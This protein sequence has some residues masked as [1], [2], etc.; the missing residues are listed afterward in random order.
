MSWGFVL[1]TDTASFRHGFDTARSYLADRLN[2][3]EGCGR[4]LRHAPLATPSL[5]GGSTPVVTTVPG[6]YVAVTCS[7]IGESLLEEVF[8]Y[9]DHMDGLLYL[10]SDAELDHQVCQALTVD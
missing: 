10:D 3:R 4:T 6:D 8:V 5:Q 9:L 2:Q 7:T 1:T